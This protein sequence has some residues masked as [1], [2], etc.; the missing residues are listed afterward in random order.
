V[1]ANTAIPENVPR[2]IEEINRYYLTLGVTTSTARV[3]F[4]DTV[5]RKPEYELAEDELKELDSFLEEF[6]RV[7]EDVGDLVSMRS[8][9]WQ[10]F[11][12]PVDNALMAASHSMREILRKII[13]QFA[14]NKVLEDAKAEPAFSAKKKITKKERLKFLLS[15]PAGQTA[16]KEMVELATRKCYEVYTRLEEVAHGSPGEREEVK[17]SI[18]ITEHT[19]LSILR[20]WKL[21]LKDS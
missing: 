21:R 12:S 5:Y 19:L 2:N 1:S 11:H 3:V 16:A 17:R 14:S 8:G 18:R 15:G 6:S 9:A 10:T 4:F 7:F 13:S 20:S